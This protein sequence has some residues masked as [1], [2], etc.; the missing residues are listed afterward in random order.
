MEWSSSGPD[1][2]RALLELSKYSDEGLTTRD[3]VPCIN[4][5]EGDQQFDD[6]DDDR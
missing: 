4:D 1:F 3:G 5:G 6:D 2:P